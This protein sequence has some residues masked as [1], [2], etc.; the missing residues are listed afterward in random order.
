MEGIS[1]LETTL[2]NEA[3]AAAAAPQTDALNAPSKPV[4]G[5]EEIFFELDD[6]PVRILS[7]SSFAQAANTSNHAPRPE[8]RKIN[9]YEISDGGVNLA[10]DRGVFTGDFDAANPE[11][12]VGQTVKGRYKITKFLGGDESGLKFIGEDRLIS[13]RKVL[14]LI[15]LH[16]ESDEIMESILAEERVSLSHLSHPNIARLIDSG[17]FTNG[18][19]FLVNEFIDALSVR[20]IIDI[21]GQ[22]G[23]MRAARTIE[24][25]ASALSH[26]H[27]EGILHRDITPENL[28][29]DAESD[30]EHVMLVNFGSSNGEPNALN[31]FYKAP[32]VLDGYISTAASDIY[33]L[34]VIA[35]EMLTGKLPFTGENTRELARNQHA[36][37]TTKVTDIRPDLPTAVDDVLL[38]AFSFDAADRYTKARE[39]GEAF[40]HALLGPPDS[41]PHVSAKPASKVAAPVKHVEKLEPLVA[42]EQKAENSV[43]AP[44]TDEP[45]WTRRSPEPPKF[46]DSRRR[47]IAFA[48]IGALLALLAIGWYYIVS[49]PPSEPTTQPTGSVPEGQTIVP[50]TDMPPLPRNIPQPPNTNFYQSTKQNLKGDLLLNF[51]GFSMYYPKDWRVNGPQPGT[52]ADSRGKFVDI[53]SVDSEGRMKEQMLVSYYPSKGTFKDDADKF[54]QLVKETNETLKKILPGYQVVSEGEIRLNG[55]WSA[56]EVKFQASGTDANGQNLAVWGRRLFVP[57]ARPSV[58]NGFMITMLATSFADDVK[59]VND[60]GVKGELAPILYSFEPSQNF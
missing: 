46:E 49:N 55:D 57:A 5:E 31:A 24:Q 51:V 44:A 37:L 59:S 39:F 56:Y 21:H 9:P 22:F 34:A 10:D 17:E 32:E 54:P 8:P 14:V 58:R 47:R 3:F 33:S 15:L 20:E 35:Y 1:D 16:R 40:S 12:F 6:E 27:Q 26:A 23:D 43:S 41:V 4:N 38:K 42:K 52:T 29:L 36:G 45:M 13:E 2:R 18:T 11:S 60:V 7:D 53:S 25:V 19:E 50:A 48:G 30:N 28:I